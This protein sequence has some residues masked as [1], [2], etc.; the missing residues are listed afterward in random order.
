MDHI[1]LAFY[2]SGDTWPPDQRVLRDSLSE[3]VSRETQ[4]FLADHYQTEIARWRR[5]KKQGKT[6]VDVQ[7]ELISI[8]KP[9]PPRPG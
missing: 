2:E 4:Q 7:W 1:I 6:F 8:V 5:A 3:S 9:N